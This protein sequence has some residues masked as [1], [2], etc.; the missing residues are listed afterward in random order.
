MNINEP[1]LLE[2]NSF[3]CFLLHVSSLIIRPKVLTWQLI[4]H[5]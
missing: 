5:V 4:D 2:K 3:Q 1:P